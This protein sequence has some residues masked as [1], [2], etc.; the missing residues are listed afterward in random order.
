MKSSYETLGVCSDRDN[1]SS[2]LLAPASAFSFE[3]PT[4][5]FLMHTC[6]KYKGT[7][8]RLTFRKAQGIKH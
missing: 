3:P 1:R 4:T 5:Y 2:D 6:E 7:R 8:C